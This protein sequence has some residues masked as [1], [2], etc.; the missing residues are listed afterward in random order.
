MKIEKLFAIRLKEDDSLCEVK[1]IYD[2]DDDNL[3]YQLLDGVEF[4]SIKSIRIR[5]ESGLCV[6]S[7]NIDLQQIEDI[8]VREFCLESKQ[9]HI[10]M[11]ERRLLGND[12][13]E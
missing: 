3:E 10:D 11:A 9:A 6:W 7:H 5:E 12:Y 8:M 4:D 13:D 2:F 1:F